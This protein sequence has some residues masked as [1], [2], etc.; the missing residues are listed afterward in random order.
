MAKPWATSHISTVA[1]G[2]G[3]ELRISGDVKTQ[4][5]DIL[6]HQLKMITQEM[7]NQT[8]ESDPERKTLD[9]PNRMRLG[10][11]RTRGMM[12]DNISRV[13]SIGAAAVVAANEQLENYLL[14][15]LRLSS[16]AAAIERVGTIKPRHL[17]KALERIDGGLSKQ[18]NSETEEIQLDPIE[19][20][21]GEI[22]GDILTPTML[23]N[24]AKKFAGKPLDNDAL[25][26]LLLLYYDHASNI[27]HDLQDNLANASHIIQMIERFQSLTMLGWMRRMLKEAGERADRTES[28]TVTLA[29]I[30][31]VD[32][33]D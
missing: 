19:D 31:E 14:R 21:M 29:H 9:D 28:K 2:L 26:E 8:L 27:Q 20:V 7:E 22:S 18:E 25:E 1:S 11:S 33:W 16:D 3:I 17:D 23:R 15:L 24:M 13:D 32:P 6:E 12:I 30:V 5:V 4:L 10:F